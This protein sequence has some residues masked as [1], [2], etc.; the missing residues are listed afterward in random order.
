MSR[1]NQPRLRRGATRVNTSRAGPGYACSG[2]SGRAAA[3]PNVSISVPPSRRRIRELQGRPPVRGRLHRLQ[4]RNHIPR[5]GAGALQLL[6]QI[7][8]PPPSFKSIR[9]TGLSCACT[10]VCCTTCVVPP[11]ENASGCETSCT[12][13]TFRLK[14]PS[15]ETGCKRTVPPIT[16]VPV[17]SFT[18]TRARGCL[19]L[20][21][22]D[23]VQSRR[24]ILVRQRGNVRP[25]AAAA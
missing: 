22:L 13:I 15:E 4:D 23:L 2:R 25:A 8:H 12:E 14:P 3:A 21:G 11:V 18:T 1:V 20:D 19:D 16:T 17:R 24:H 5:A 6:H 10:E 7:L 9:F